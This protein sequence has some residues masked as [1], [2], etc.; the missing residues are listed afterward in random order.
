M[1]N[2]IIESLA[3]IPVGWRVFF[4][5]MLPITEL[6]GAIP[7]GVLWEMPPIEAFCWAVAGNFFPVIPLL[8]CLK[9][10]LRWLLGRPR[11]RGLAWR[12]EER[13]ALNQKKIQRYGMMGLC[14]LVA[15]PLP[16]TGAWTGALVAAVLNL[17]FLP[18]V[19]A[20]TIG[21]LIAG[22]LVCLLVSGAVALTQ[23]DYGI[24]VLAIVLFFGLLYLFRKKFKK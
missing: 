4:L 13:A 15:I 2:S 20:I 5:A 3:G 11:L 16:G 8:L 9:C 24:W 14:L 6:R 19:L 12:L 23:L 10:F 21:E 18:S 7:L 1:L 17:R 22:I